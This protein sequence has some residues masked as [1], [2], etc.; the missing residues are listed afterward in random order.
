M[1]IAKVM[2]VT[3]DQEG[4][5][6]LYVTSYSG[7]ESL[8]TTYKEAMKACKKK[9]IGLVAFYNNMTA[10]EIYYDDATK[11]E[12]RAEYQI[13]KGLLGGILLYGRNHKKLCTIREN[14]EEQA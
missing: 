12:T 14:K 13:S 2:S 9:K 4:N 1:W 11:K 6:Q 10:E 7:N 8:K 5:E 3:T